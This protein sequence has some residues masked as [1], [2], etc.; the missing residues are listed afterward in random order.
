MNCSSE[1]AVQDIKYMYPILKMLKD[2]ILEFSQKFYQR[3]REKKY[4]GF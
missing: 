1:E 4:Y 3:K 2:L